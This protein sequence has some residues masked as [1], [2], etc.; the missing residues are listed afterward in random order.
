MRRTEIVE[1]I[2]NE[3]ERFEPVD[4]EFIILY[5]TSQLSEVDE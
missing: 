4:I 1:S 2:E 3:I 5:V